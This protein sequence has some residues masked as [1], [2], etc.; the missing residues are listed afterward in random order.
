MHNLIS[1]IAN[2]SFGV[3]IA[4]VFIFVVFLCFYGGILPE[5][6]SHASVVKN[7]F[8]APLYFFKSQNRDRAYVKTTYD[9]HNVKASMGALEV[10]YTTSKKDRVGARTTAYTLDGFYGVDFNAK[11]SF[12]TKLNVILMSD[13]KT[14]FYVATIELSTNWEAY[15]LEKDKF[16]PVKN[17]A[18]SELRLTQDEQM[19]H[20]LPYLE[21]S[22]PP[23]DHQI[24]GKFWIDSLSV[25]RK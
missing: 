21:W 23:T 25:Y 4:I 18:L 5:G 3:F 20:L 22:V 17:P 11:A 14:Y 12:P 6:I 10:D 15:R 2:I 9:K 8:D 19:K 24:T 7:E 13:D 16:S 1:K